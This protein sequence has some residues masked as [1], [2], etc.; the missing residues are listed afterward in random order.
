M[1]KNKTVVFVLFLFGQR[2]LKK[3]IINE[4]K[5]HIAAKI[6]KQRCFKERGVGVREIC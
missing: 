1:P 6:I 4:A 3:F 2:K 5:R